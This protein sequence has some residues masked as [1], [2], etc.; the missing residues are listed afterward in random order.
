MII[1]EL[2]NLIQDGENI[3]VEFK[4]KVSTPEK[5]AKEMIAFANT[6]GG[7]ILFGVDDNKEIIGVNSEKEEL[8]LIKTAARYYCEPH[9]KYSYEILL[10]RH[11]DIIIIKVDESKIKPHFLF[12]EEKDKKKAFIRLNDKS[13][14]ASREMVNI[15]RGLNIDSTPVT[16]SL[17]ENEK[18]LLK[19]LEENESINVK[20]YK[21]IANISERRAS[22]TLVN[23]TRAKILMHQRINEKEF[24]T[25]AN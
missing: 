3:K 2:E 15:M 8:E 1:P 7:V 19:Y 16:I 5:I 17:G 11:K 18:I 12:S 24:F 22:R 4:R 9:I 14:I 6:N 25:L 23:L 10:Y 20:T 21:K 13:V